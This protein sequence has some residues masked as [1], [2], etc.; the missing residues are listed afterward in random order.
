MIISSNFRK[1]TLTLNSCEIYFKNQEKLQ[2]N[3]KV[4]SAVLLL[5]LG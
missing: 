3:L 1:S 4:H 2:I 5:V